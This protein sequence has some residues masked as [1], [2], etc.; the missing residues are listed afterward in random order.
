LEFTAGLN[1]FGPGYFSK[2]NSTEMVKLINEFDELIFSQNLSLLDCQI[3]YYHDFGK[4]IVGYA[5]GEIVELDF[6]DE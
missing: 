4:T 6:D 2:E 3:E 5:K 1:G